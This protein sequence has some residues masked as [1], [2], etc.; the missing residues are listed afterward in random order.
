[1][2]KI[3]TQIRRSTIKEGGSQNA[4]TISGGEAGILRR[5][6]KWKG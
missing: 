4:V 3:G 1:M 6:M 5:F 2:T